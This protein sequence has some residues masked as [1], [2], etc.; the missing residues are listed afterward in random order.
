MYSYV[1]DSN[2]QFDPFGQTITHLHHTIPREIYNPRSG[3]PAL[4]PEHLATDRDIIGKKGNP[5]RWAVPADEHIALHKKNRPG[6]DYNTRWKQE[7]GKL[8]PDK[9]KWTKKDILD[10]R[11]KLTKEFE[12]D[13]YKPSCK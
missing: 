6:G 8:D 1:P 10:I 13:K 3:K 2:S 7:I 11:D 4:L 12:I 5:N 9:S